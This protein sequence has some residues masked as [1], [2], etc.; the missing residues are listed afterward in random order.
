MTEKKYI[1]FDLDG[2]L[3][4]PMV[5]ITK[6]VQYALRMYGIEVEDLEQLCCFI[7]PPLKDSFMEYYGFSEEAAGEA[8]FKYRDYFS[9]TG[10]YENK[11]YPGIKHLLESLL[12]AGKKL[13]LATSKP[14]VFA[15]QILEYF[16][17]DS[18]FEFVGGANLE[19]TRVRKGDVIQ[20]V[21]DC[22]QISDLSQVV[23]IGDRKHDVIGAKE[24]GVDCV[25][26]LYGYGSREE[27]EEA[28]ADVI[29]GSVQDLHGLLLENR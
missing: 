2:T 10:L 20:H 29:V 3:T 28:G 19:E 27:L 22:N 26:V 23:M 4:D 18:Y 14:D 7:G 9:V 21:L 11:E 25:G 8:V 1:L 12:K 6:S 16:K 13:M 17:L 24:T 15:V 5:G